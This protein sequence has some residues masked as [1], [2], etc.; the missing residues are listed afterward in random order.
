M[1]T[2]VNRVFAKRETENSLWSGRLGVAE[3]KVDG[4]GKWWL[5]GNEL[6]AASAAYLATFALQSLQDAYAG[7]KSQADAV[8]AW[9]KK[10]NALL[11][12]TIGVRTGGGG[13]SDP[14]ATFRRAIV[15][16][17]LTGDNAAEYKAIPSDDQ[18]A[19]GE[20]LDAKYAALS[21][22]KQDVVDE[23]AEAD[24][25]AAIERAKAAKAAAN[26]IGL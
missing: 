16:K 5:D 18:K 21:Y 19:R 25:A 6:P 24:R 11:A 10:R 7:A 20:W 1:E 22:D 12:G 3:L 17:A 26:D 2:I 15:R 13:D 8:A 23:R 14:L 9:E 4:K